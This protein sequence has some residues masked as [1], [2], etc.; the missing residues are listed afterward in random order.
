M[1]RKFKEWERSE[2]GRVFVFCL[3]FCLFR[4]SKQRRIKSK[5]K[6]VTPQKTNKK[7]KGK[8][9]FVALLAYLVHDISGQQG[10]VQKMNLFFVSH[11]EPKKENWKMRG[12]KT[13]V[14][15]KQQKKKPD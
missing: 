2:F 1:G 11:F 14:T 8:D 15:T 12:E 6:D 10:S 5:E 7:V 9:F 13:K 3:C 4:S